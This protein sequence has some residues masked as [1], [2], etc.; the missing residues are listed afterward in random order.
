[1]T[2]SPEAQIKM[3]LTYFCALILPLQGIFLPA[4]PKLPSGLGKAYVVKRSPFRNF[5]IYEN[6]LK[7]LQN[8]DDSG[9]VEH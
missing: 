7:Q 2:F 9:F 6:L 4:L 8:P 5:L 1:M 3:I